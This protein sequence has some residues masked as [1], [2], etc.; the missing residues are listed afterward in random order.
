LVDDDIWGFTNEEKGDD[1]EE[2]S[3]QTGFF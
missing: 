3:H 2:K 1:Q